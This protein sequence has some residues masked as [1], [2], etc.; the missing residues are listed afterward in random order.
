[1]PINN[2]HPS[3]GPPATG[4]RRRTWLALLVGG[5]AVAV[6]AIALARTDDPESAISSPESTTSKTAGTTTSIT[7]EDQVVAR[8][9]EILKIR[10]RAYR[11]RDVL[12]LREVYSADCPCLRGDEG[13]IKRL[14]AEDAVWVGS[15]TSVS[16][17]K[18]D[19]ESN[20]LWIVE[21]IFTGSPFRIETESGDLIRA[22][23][24]QRELFRFALVDTVDG[25]RLG[26]AAPVE[27]SDG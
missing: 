18:L 8:L 2:Q 21:A 23:D 7:E 24:E 10:D 12:L 4:L 15:S 6:A 1:M 3:I 5:L 25:L 13:A 16:V 19:R 11:H 14:I 9:R 20:R 26:L 27:N 22:V 17:R